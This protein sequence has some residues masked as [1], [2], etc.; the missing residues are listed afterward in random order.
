MTQE[1]RCMSCNKLLGKVSVKTEHGDFDINLKCARCKHQQT[2]TV[3]INNV[4]DQESQD[5]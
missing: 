1:I 4:E 5:K 2:Y 3:K